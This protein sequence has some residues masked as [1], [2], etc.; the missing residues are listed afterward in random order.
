MSETSS[1][2][3]LQ[4]AFAGRLDQETLGALRAVARRHTYPA[5]TAVFHQGERGHTF[6]II[7][8]GRIAVVQQLE[9]GT[10]R[11]LNSMGSGEYF[12][13][14]GL[15]DDKPRMATCLTLTESTLLE[16]DEPIF[17]RLTSENPTVAHIMMHL[18]LQRA[19]QMDQL[20][21]ADLQTKNLELHQAYADLQAA[22]EKVVEKERL[23]RELE[24]A[25]QAQ[26][27][28]LPGRLPQ[29]TDFR[30]AAYLQPARQ[31]GGDFYDVVTLDDEHV[32]LLLADVADKGFHAALIMAVTRA[33]FWEAAR[34]HLAPGE[35]AQIVHQG[36]QDVMQS[37]NVFVT[38]FYGV[39][40]RPSGI[41]RYVR[42]GQERPL[43]LRPGQ[44]ITPI[45]GEGRFL[46]MIDPLHLDEYTMQLLPGDRLVMFSDG[47][48][49]AL[50]PQ[51]Q[52][53]NLERLLAALEQQQQLS[54]PQLVDLVCLEVQRWRQSAPNFDDLTLLV[55]EAVA[56][57][58]N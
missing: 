29:F 24:L 6:Y 21:I 42:A 33:L 13:E 38:A 11:L 3:I 23:E 54:A 53:Y 1:T 55:A 40:H 32:G 52:H 17:D 58:Q 4:H 19:R 18:I 31:V 12:G 35:V 46:G 27:N 37:D 49:D 51:G 9:D 41:L 28:L 39:L 22:Q 47:V 56:A 5:G 20:A 14:M 30:F 43:L 57:A 16:I 48:T 15:I 50:N 25:A 8:T 34:H 26:R 45:P 10:E 36:M 44:P 2:L 7:V